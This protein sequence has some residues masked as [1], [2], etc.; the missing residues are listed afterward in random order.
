MHMSEQARRAS[1]LLHSWSVNSSFKQSESARSVNE[2]LNTEDNQTNCLANT[3]AM[4]RLG[5]ILASMGN[6]RGLA[7]TCIPVHE[8]SSPFSGSCS[9]MWNQLGGLCG[10]SGRIVHISDPSAGWH[11]KALSKHSRIQGMRVLFWRGSLR[12]GC[13]YQGWQQ[14]RKLPKWQ[15]R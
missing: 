13:H 8:K 4:E 5:S 7:L 14:A 1:A 6:R 15:H 12:N 9:L 2:L 3:I 11:R 10:P